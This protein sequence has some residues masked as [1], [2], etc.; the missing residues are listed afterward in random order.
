MLGILKP[1]SYEKDLVLDETY[2]YNITE[3]GKQLGRVISTGNVVIPNVKSI[4]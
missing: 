3:L 2:I 4:L 1:P